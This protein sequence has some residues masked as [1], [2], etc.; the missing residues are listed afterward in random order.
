[1]AR[2]GDRP[3]DRML[4]TTVAATALCYA[5]GYPLALIGKSS[6]GWVF[7]SLGGIFLVAAVWL[8]IRRVHS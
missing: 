2:P 1:M 8:F 5:I 6:V 4:W 7:V 3:D